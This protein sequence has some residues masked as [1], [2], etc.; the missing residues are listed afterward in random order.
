MLSAVVVVVVV[1][2]LFIKPE[3]LPLGVYTYYCWAV[4]V[5]RHSLEEA[6][7]GTFWARWPIQSWKQFYQ[8]A[9]FNSIAECW[10]RPVYSGP[11]RFIDVGVR[12][13]GGPGGTLRLTEERVHAI[14]CASYNYGGYGQQVPRAVTMH[15]TYNQRWAQ[16]LDMSLNI[17]ALLGK[18]GVV[19]CASGYAT[20]AHLLPLLID[21]LTNGGNG[22]VLVL[23]DELNHTSIVVGIQHARRHLP[24]N[25]TLRVHAHN[26]VEALD[27]AYEEAGGQAYAVCLVVFESLYSMEGHFAPLRDL[28][29][30][31]RR[32]DNVML[33]M[34]EAHSFAAL[35]DT[36]R[37]LCELVGVA[38]EEVAFLMGTTSKACAANGGYIAC[39]SPQFAAA[40]S[41]AYVRAFDPVPMP[42]LC[43]TQ[44]RDVVRALVDQKPEAMERLR[45]LRRNS[46][47][48]TRLLL[49]ETDCEV[50]SDPEG[51]SPVITVRIRDPG[52]IGELNQWC[53]HRAAV[54][55]VTVGYP[56]LPL[57][58][59]GRIRLCVSA[60]HELEDL[61]AVAKA[62]G[63]A[64]RENHCRSVPRTKA[65][66][67]ATT[68]AAKWRALPLVQPRTIE[69]GPSIFAAPYLTEQRKW[70]NG[71]EDGSVPIGAATQATLE[72][73]GVGSCGPYYFYGTMGPH[74][75]LM[76]CLATLYGRKHAVVF[77]HAETALEGVLPCIPTP[78]Q[79]KWYVSSA[80]QRH[81]LSVRLAVVQEQTSNLEEADVALLSPAE[82]STLQTRPKHRFVIVYDPWDLVEPTSKLRDCIVIGTLE[83]PSVGALG[84][85]VCMDDGN[86]MEHVRLY[87]KSLVFS[88]SPAPYSST[89]AAEAIR[90]MFPQKK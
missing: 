73:Y 18:P 34:D 35:G 76:Q 82:F 83:G 46:R 64:R 48:L 14:N 47:E 45:R 17:G 11:G 27:R 90:A 63:E 5:I 24:N 44:V 39:P 36:G 20:N 21:M 33:Y 57:A 4:A 43:S 7:R 56:A 50:M 60:A 9:A 86:T 62:I 88:A 74:L 52:M 16:Q 2:L 22:R 70:W 42:L 75:D 8:L 53:L 67:A 55:I 81:S 59:G 61:R 23:S 69:W 84:A 66:A 85:Y 78:P 58:E 25:V 29:A 19:A 1:V 31:K 37:G 13:R 72:R 87:A 65:V 32:R 89:Q 6:W 51:R 54:A 68:P 49:E 3:W 15:G 41:D 40:L 26:D 77:P 71:S 12:D 28:V 80:L 38:P 30:W 10:G 79:S